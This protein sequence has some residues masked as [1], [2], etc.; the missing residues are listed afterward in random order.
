M[1]YLIVGNQNPNQLERKYSEWAI[2]F[3]EHKSL[4]KIH[5]GVTDLLSQSPDFEMGFLQLAELPAAQVRYILRKIEEYKTTREF[6][7]AW[8]AV[9]IEHILPQTPSQEWIDEL[10]QDEEELEEMTRKLGNLE[11]APEI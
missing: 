10:A 4:D 6:D 2:T 3:R 1:R 9:N 7:L 8:K 5:K 11:V